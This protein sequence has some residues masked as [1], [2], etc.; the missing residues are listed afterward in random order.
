MEIEVSGQ[1]DHSGNLVVTQRET[2]KAWLMKNR[3]KHIVLT[4]ETKK[5]KRSNPQN[6]FY[7][8]VVI[9]MV[10]KGMS[11]FGHR[12]TKDATHDFL[13]KQF[14]AKEIELIEGHY[15]DMPGSTTDLN[16]TEFMDYLLKI[17]QF[18]S[19]MLNIYI[20]DP[21]EFLEIEITQSKSR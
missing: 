16:I 4:I 15:V 5:K 14:N 3:D 11:D 13:K 20:P 1:V 6:A 7:W 21:N 10:Q 19:D 18:G 9:P 12:F 2:L 8:G 17:Q